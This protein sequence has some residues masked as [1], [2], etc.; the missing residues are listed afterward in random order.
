M[1]ATSDFI[2]YLVGLGY[3]E[4][5]AKRIASG[6]LPMD[7]AS[8]MARAEAQ[9]YDLVPKYHTGAADI[10]EIKTEPYPYTENKRAFWLADMPEVSASYG[11]PNANTMYEMLIKSGQLDQVDAGGR[12]WSNLQDAPYTRFDGSDYSIPERPSGYRTT[13]DYIDVARNL[14][15]AGVQ[16]NNVYDFGA[17]YPNAKRVIEERN[18]DIKATDWIKQFERSG[19]GHKTYAVLDENMVR[20]AD[21]AFDPE[22]TGPNIMGSRV[23]PTAG[24][25]LITA[26]ALAPDQVQAQELDPNLPVTVGRPREELR[27]NYGGGATIP[28]RPE[29]QGFNFAEWNANRPIERPPMDATIAPLENETMFEAEN[30]L[31]DLLGGGY[32]GYESARNLINVADFLPFVGSGISLQQGADAYRQGKVGEGRL[33]T[34]IGLLEAIPVAGKM[35]SEALQGMRAVRQARR[36][37][38]AFAGRMNE[39]AMNSMPRRADEDL[40]GLLG[41]Q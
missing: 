7:K 31:G 38:D 10:R 29:Y 36:L 39:A 22:Y 23:I 12:A 11:N 17:G 37:D 19:E 41:W 3:P 15:S 16:F 28:L 24:A 6:E 14:D 21:A 1:T 40:M 30:A 26:A 18:P 32:W 25:G 20:S 2:R 27:Y 4:S 13:D 5:V 8:R 9:G 35:A 33:L 34:G